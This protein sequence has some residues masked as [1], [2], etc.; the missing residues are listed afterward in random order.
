MYLIRFGIIGILI[1]LVASTGCSNMTA[2][3]SVPEPGS[4]GVIHA[5]QAAPHQLWGMYQFTCSPAAGTVDITT[6]R[7]A[8]MHLNVISML[9]NPP[10]VYL[11]LES[12]PQFTGDNLEVDIGL[13]HPLLGNDYFTGF[14]VCGIFISNGTVN[15]LFDPALVYAAEDE[16]RLIN[17]DG[18][19]RWW[20]PVEFPFN[21]SAPMQG[22]YDGALGTPDSIADYSAT[23]NGYKYFADGL[24]PDDDLDTLDP[25]G[26]GVFSAGQKNIRHYFIHLGGGLTFNYAVDA[27]WAIPDTGV[28]PIEVPDDFP[29]AAN[30]PEAWFIHVDEM[31]NTLFYDENL[32]IGGGTFSIEID[33]YDHFNADMNTVRAESVAGLGAVTTSEP[34]DSGN[35]YSTYALELTGESLTQNGWIETLISV[36]SEVSDYNGKLPGEPVTAYFLEWSY[37]QENIPGDYELVFPDPPVTLSDSSWFNSDNEWPRVIENGHHWIIVGWQQNPPDNGDVRPVD[38]VSY[39]KGETWDPMDTSISSGGELKQTKMALDSSGFAYQACLHYDSDG[40][41]ASTP[42]LV[43]CPPYGDG[44]WGWSMGIADRSLEIIFTHDGYPLYF[45]DNGGKI[46]LKKGKVAD[47]CFGTAPN[48]TSWHS[49]TVHDVAPSTALLSYG[50]SIVRDDTGAIHLAYMDNSGVTKIWTVSNLDG[51]GLNWSEPFEVGFGAG[52]VVTVHDPAMAYDDYGGL[53]L[54]YI[55]EF[56][57][58][59]P[60]RRI[61]HE[62]SPSGTPELLGGFEDATGTFTFMQFPSVD[63]AMLPI[64][65]TPVVA[66]GTGE[67]IGT[68]KDVQVAWKHPVTGVWSDEIQVD[69]GGDAQAPSMCVDSSNYVHVVWYEQNDI[70][71]NQVMYRRGEFVLQ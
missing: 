61:I 65:L 69:M 19:T 67:A 49:L 25:S 28:P 38:I 31:E 29:P 16:T 55:I 5:T 9:E 56:A 17:T 46:T 12:P 35:G 27:C 50:S 1:M 51:T 43:R 15:G 39:D 68:L 36:E 21:P 8:G 11:T 48:S 22:Y 20:N 18:L 42:Y 23:L 41:P 34:I 44:Y 33:V 14:D 71:Q 24:G 64:G 60:M 70:W 62:Y 30:R 66:A 37:V 6:L 32:S 59:I 52:G 53:H 13:R 3:P 57:E 7:Y 40:L 54:V 47:T 2:D 63:A 26:R 4:S 10:L 45:L 58:V